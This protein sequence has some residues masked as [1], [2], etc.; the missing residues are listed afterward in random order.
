MSTD[1][2]VRGSSPAM[3]T[4]DVLMELRT[5]VKAMSA[6]VTVM[7]SQNL[8]QRVNALESWADRING[9][10]NVLMV[11]IGILGS[12]VGISLGVVTL[13]RVLFPPG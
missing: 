11:V 9:R 12:I 6:V 10:V 7:A 2:D 8:D 1:E 4:K 5:D 3:S 13:L